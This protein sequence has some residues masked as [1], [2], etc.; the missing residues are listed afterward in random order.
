MDLLGT[1]EI[2]CA[3][4]GDQAIAIT[5]L[6]PYIV[7]R[8]TFASATAQPTGCTGGI[9][10]GTNQTGTQIVPSTQS[11]G[12]LGHLPNRFLDAGLSTPALD[13]SFTNSTL[14]FNSSTPASQPSSCVLYIWGDVLN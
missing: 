2:D 8:V 7:R 12:L 9:Y 3:A 4:A 14:Y 10:A 1:T 5:V 13:C 11:Y 6:H